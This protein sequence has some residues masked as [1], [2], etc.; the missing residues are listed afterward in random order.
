MYT[1]WQDLRFALR[2]LSKNP[3]FTCVAI[4]TLALGIG[5]NVTVFTLANAVLFKNLPFPNSERILYI[6][7]VNR[8]NGN[9]VPMSYPDFRDYSS[10]VKSFDAVGAFSDNN[11]DVSD[12]NGNA[13]LY[14]GMLLS[15]NGFS[16]IGQ[17][18]IAGRDFLPEDAR[19]GAAPVTI[20]SY[21]MWE[22]RYARNPSVIGQ[23]IHINEIPTVIIG[24]MPRG[25]Q[26]PSESDLWMPLI[27]AGDWEK[28]EYRN[29]TMFGRLTGRATLA[30]ASAEMETIGRRLEAEYS[31]TNKDIAPR[32]KTFNEFSNSPE[33]TT[34]FL[35]LLGAVG[36][37]LLIACANVANLLLARAVGRSREVSIRAALGASRWRV[38]RQLLVESVLLS[39]VGGA[40]GWLGAL[41]GIRVFDAAVSGNGKPAFIIFTMDY[42]VL[43]YIAAVTIGTGILFG[44]APALRLSKLDINAAL[45]DGGHGTSSGARG[46]YLSAILV[47]AEMAL[48]VV[49]LTGAGLMIR[50]FLKAYRAPIGVDAHNVMTMR[51]YLRPAKYAKPDDEKLFHQRLQ[52]RIASLPGVEETAITSNIPGGGTLGFPFEIEGAPPVDDRRR[53]RTDAIVISP[54]YFDVM[55]VRP[56]F[57][58]PFTESDGVTGFAVVIV[59]KD[60]ADT[61]WPSQD[62]MGKRLRLVTQPVGAAPGIPAAPQSWLTVVG[63][64][65]KILQNGF[66][67]DKRDPIIYLPYRQQPMRGMSIVIRTQGRPETLADAFRREVQAVDADLPVFNMR[68][69]E[70][71]FTRR[72]WPWR[73]FG[74]MFA[75][76]A[77]IA[78]LLAS[79]GLYAVIAHSVSQRTQEIGIRVA[80]GAST[81][82]VLRLVLMQGMRQ[83]VSGLVVGLLAA[84]GITR[85]LSILLIGVTPNDPATFITVAAILTLA[86]VL[87]CLIPARRA[88]HVDPVVAL[89]HD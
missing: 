49:L 74:G 50:S 9:T 15:A 26:F 36:F 1:L 51:M 78:L 17:K 44:L 6:Y 32:V 31:A 62:P 41:W 29:M 28:R 4:L 82:N 68:T 88:T 86:G 22:N 59:N 20:L 19:P 64:V 75:I 33:I 72:T 10:Q 83:L 55:K 57:G 52:A 30:S 21:G 53:Q 87:G 70:D 25:L 2:T 43:A 46:K 69:L 58:R 13:Q 47:V 48:A 23:T 66:D 42:R 5:A 45:K 73:V 85:V 89:R 27:P 65:P 67:S 54:D 84:F 40:L 7:C 38:I 56:L 60:F 12:T 63:V 16:V 34:V 3:G 76:F 8:S 14:D 80:L 79:V 81:W 39:I 18:P 11:V 77:A 24:V 71:S 37:V 61:F 35:A